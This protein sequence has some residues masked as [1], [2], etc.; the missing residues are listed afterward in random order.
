MPQE[1]RDIPAGDVVVVGVDG[2][3]DSHA[4]L[5]WAAE[6]AVRLGCGLLV[7]HVW[8]AIPRFAELPPR[9]QAALEQDRARTVADA[10]H[11]VADALTEIGVSD[12][13]FVETL[14]IDGSPGSYLVRLSA[15]TTQVVLGATGRGTPEG[16]SRPPIGSTVRYVLR[17][18]YCP[19]TVISG[20]RIAERDEATYEETDTADLTTQ[21]G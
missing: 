3:P 19:V 4:A 18:A 14:V 11:R 7:V 15:R 1:H 20:K 5:S 10:Q 2:S 8:T 21:S 13:G 6:Q 16:L 9:S 12:R 17:H